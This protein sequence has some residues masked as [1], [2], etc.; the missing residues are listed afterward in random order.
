MIALFEMIISEWID[1]ENTASK[2]V[3]FFVVVLYSSPNEQTNACRSPHISIL[4]CLLR[5]TD[6]HSYIINTFAD[7]GEGGETYAYN[8]GLDVSRCAL[9]C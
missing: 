3:L 2:R 9:R 7:R 4:A 6:S 5:R 8:N 1:I